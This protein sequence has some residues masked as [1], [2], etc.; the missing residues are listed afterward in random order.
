MKTL[1]INKCMER[2]SGDFYAIEDFK[3]FKT[4]IG[5]NVNIG[6]PQQDSLSELY[7]SDTVYVL[8]KV[9]E[10]RMESAGR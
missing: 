5:V 8:R 4:Q 2:N 6:E 7:D 10:N 1:I 3:N 9:E